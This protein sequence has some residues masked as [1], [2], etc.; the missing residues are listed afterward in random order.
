MKHLHTAIWLSALACSSNTAQPTVRVAAAADL[1][2]AF[3]ELG[4]AF[5]TTTGVKLIVEFGSSGLLARQIEHGAPYALFAAANTSYVHDVAAAG[6]CDASS[7][8]DYARGRL[9]VWTPSGMRAPVRI[10]DLAD[11][12]FRRIAIANPAHAPYGLAAK[13]ALERAGIWAQVEPR[14][15]LGENIRATLSY[16]QTGAADAAVVAMSL[17]ETSTGGNA[18]LVDP[19]LHDPL[20]QGLIVCGQGE[21]AARA[22]QLAAFIQSPGGR[23][24]MAR[25]GFAPPSEASPGAAAEFRP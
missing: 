14:L 13:Q 2:R 17:A 15:V 4:R 5:E 3:D 8:A 9:V 24:I 6:R 10:E 22:R 21:E 19:S 18:L 11:T 7:L 20:D 1:S 25:Y 23:E 12:R 16:A